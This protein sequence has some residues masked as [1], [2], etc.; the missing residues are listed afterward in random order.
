M[1][2]YLYL[3]NMFIEDSFNLSVRQAFPP[4]PWVSSEIRLNK[5]IYL[6]PV[7]F[8][9]QMS[10]SCMRYTGPNSDRAV[11]RLFLKCEFRIRLENL[12]S[13]RHLAD[14]DLAIFL[15]CQTPKISVL[16]GKFVNIRK[17]C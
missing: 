6:V 14:P 9:P 3:Y 7:C 15:I 12:V 17:S 8:L 11:L 16:N 10:F 13:L 1:K 2:Q 5:L 4:Q